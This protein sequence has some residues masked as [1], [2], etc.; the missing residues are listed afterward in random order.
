MLQ[1]DPKKRIST[2]DAYRH[3]YFWEQDPPPCNL[4]FLQI[5]KKVF[6]KPTTTKSKVKSINS[7]DEL[8]E[9]YS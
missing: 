2:T 9:I 7:I 3:S 4:S 5:P 8:L 6:P 1:L